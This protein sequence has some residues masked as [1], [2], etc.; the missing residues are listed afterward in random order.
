MRGVF[1]FF[2][3]LLKLIF[4]PIRMLVRRFEN[5]RCREVPAGSPVSYRTRRRNVVALVN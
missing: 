5:L 3:V 2:H 4:L 1:K